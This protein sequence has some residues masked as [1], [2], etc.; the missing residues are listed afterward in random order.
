[1]NDNIIPGTNWFAPL[2]ENVN[3]SRTNEFQ[4]AIEAD[5]VG[6]PNVVALHENVYWCGCQMIRND[7][8]TGNNIYT[9]VGTVLNPVWV[10]N[11]SIS[12]VN[13]VFGEV[14][15]GSG[16]AWT[17]DHVAVGTISL[18]ANGQTLLLTEDYT[19]VGD[20][21]TTVMP[22]AAGTVQASYTY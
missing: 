15:T 4:Y 13:A 12:T 18:V 20:A 9:N 5:C 19:I 6:N 17:L 10:L 21:I 1:M 22:W 16:T 14:V 2:D 8:L 7:I 11:A 3:I